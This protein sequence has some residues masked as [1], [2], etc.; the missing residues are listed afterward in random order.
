MDIATRVIN[1]VV[2]DRLLADTQGLSTEENNKEE[3]R[4]I[5]PGQDSNYPEVHATGE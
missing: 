1:N 3:G 4:N 5:V 2:R